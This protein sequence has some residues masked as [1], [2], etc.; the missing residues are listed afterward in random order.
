[1]RTVYLDHAA[2]TPLDPRVLEAML[3]HLK[4]QYGNAS[5]VHALGRKARFAVEDARERVAGLLS[6]EPG[7]IIFT[8]G[9]TESDNLALKGALALQPEKGLVTSAAEHEAVLR[10]AEQL[11]RSGRT[12]RI[13]SPA[14]DGRIMPEALRQEI[15]EDTG[16]VSI[17]YAN[18]E[19]G[20]LSPVQE[21][22]AVC[23]ERGILFHTDA[24][25]TA[26][27]MKLDVRDLGADLLSLSAHKF[28]GPKGVGALY[29]RSG[30]DVQPLVEGGAQERR[31][32]GGT[33]NVA[34][35]VGMAR[36]LELA[37]DEAQE[38][39][40]HVKR[41]RERLLALLQEALRDRAILNTPADSTAAVPHIVN[42]AFPRYEGLPLDGE[43]LLLNLDLEGVCV[44][45][46]SACTSGALEPSHVLLALG[47]DRHT[48][49]AAVR[50]SMGK[51]NTLEDIE[52]AVERLA[53][54]LNRMQPAYA[55]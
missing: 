42:I 22:A 20:A 9:G 5:S 27:L 47:L 38:R 31:R 10:P 7:E 21:L 3:P 2:T 41:L 50:F 16:L 25:Q 4:E 24:V 44:S 14:R 33:E 55:R 34:G 1:M 52:Y 54:A 48:A 39:F 40:D 12:A 13:V 6:A 23:R 35:I 36:A 17:M 37:T 11:G 28:Y 46:G 26:G 29:V 18:N 45:A 15:R 8:S 30:V 32:R 43:M 51:D 53:V 19:T 49:S